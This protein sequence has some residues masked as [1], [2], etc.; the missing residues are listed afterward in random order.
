MAAKTAGCLSSRGW[1][2]GSGRQNDFAYTFSPSLSSVSASALAHAASLSASPIVHAVPGSAPAAPSSAV[3]PGELT[4]YLMQECPTRPSVASVDRGM[5]T[6]QHTG[7]HGARQD[8][9]GRPWA[10]THQ[11]QMGRHPDVIPP[12]QPRTQGWG[13]PA[14]DPA[15]RPTGPTLLAAGSCCRR[16]CRRRRPRA[17]LALANPPCRT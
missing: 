6:C 4:M 1:G 11:M 13:W 9:H 14:H 10:R 7:T 3:A 5:H 8:P 2:R 12:R 16:Q 17:L 15:P